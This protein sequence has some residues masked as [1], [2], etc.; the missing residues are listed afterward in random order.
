M[1]LYT[2]SN[3]WFPSTTILLTWFLFSVTCH[4][5]TTTT[6]IEDV[7]QKDA[8]I[9]PVDEGLEVTGRYGVK[10]PER[11][12]ELSGNPDQ[13]APDQPTPDQPA[14]D[15][16]SPEQT[17]PDQPA[18]D[19]PAPR[20][21]LKKLGEQS[22]LILDGITVLDYMIGGQDFYKHFLRKHEP[23]FFKGIPSLFT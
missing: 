11:S 7:K 22:D 13:P 1:K 3:T 17:A 4:G 9:I 5:E 20:G 6:T 14:P 23:V 16:S 21:H 15:K 12:L 10:E 18:P 8:T 19:Q 2:A